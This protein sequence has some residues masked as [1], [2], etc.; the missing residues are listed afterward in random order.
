[1]S[2]AE[3]KEN[4]KTAEITTDERSLW[5][6]RSMEEDSMALELRERTFPWTKTH[7]FGL[8]KRANYTSCCEQLDR[9]K[10]LELIYQH[11]HSIGMHQVAYSLS[12]ESQLEFQRKDQDMERTE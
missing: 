3:N 9:H 10:V 12:Q 7:S 1:M 8:L 11:L 2:E 6:S 4:E 5:L